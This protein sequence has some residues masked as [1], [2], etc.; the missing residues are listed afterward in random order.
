MLEGAA[1]LILV[2][3]KPPVSFFAWPNLPNWLTPVSCKI[4]TLVTPEQ[5]GL[6]AL[7]T[8]AEALN[9]PAEPAAVYELDRPELP[10]GEITVEKVWAALSALMPE[11]SIIS[12]E[13]VTS[14]RD[15][16]RWICGA[17][18]HDW[19]SITGGAIGQGLQAATGT[20][21]ACPD[22]KV[23]S[24]QADGSGMYTL[25]ALWTQAHEKLNVV[26]VIFSNHCYKI[27]EGELERVGVAGIGPKAR[28]LIDLTR[29]ELDWVKL[30]NGMGS[31]EKQLKRPH[32]SI[33]TLLQ[34]KRGDAG[35]AAVEGPEHA[36]G[37]KVV[38]LNRKIDLAVPGKPQLKETVLQGIDGSIE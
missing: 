34:A 1:H 11:H 6:Q 24:M 17:P 25:Q 10:T 15:A 3:A 32:R 21:V 29:P 2:G 33:C 16:D 26:T 27:L 22:R 31:L 14:R 18:A 23:F 20:A 36:P 4:H 9:A 38:P 13:G 30:A 19:L 5:D 7:K 37:R 12:D 35:H 28:K 8:L